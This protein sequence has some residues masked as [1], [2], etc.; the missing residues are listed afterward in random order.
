MDTL[1][2]D[3][4][5]PTSATSGINDYDQEGARRKPK[6][7][8]DN[9]AVRTAGPQA[10]DDL[11]DFDAEGTGKQP[12]NLAAKKKGRGTKPRRSSTGG[13]PKVPRGKAG[14]Q[15]ND[16]GDTDQW[17]CEDSNGDTVNCEDENEETDS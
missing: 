1:L 17:E 2:K 11:P 5:M 3:F 4:S 14:P 10:E 12:L 15:G 6:V 9:P 8:K 13:T 7:K 16:E